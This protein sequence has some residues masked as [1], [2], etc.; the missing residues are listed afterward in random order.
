[1]GNVAA[2]GALVA[3]LGIGNEPGAF[4]QQGTFSPAGAWTRSARFP[5]SSRRCGFVAV[6]LAIPFSPGSCRDRSGDPAA[7]NAV[8]SS[9][10]GCGHR[11]A[12]WPHRR[13]ADSNDN[14]S[15]MDR[16]AWYAKGEGITRVSCCAAVWPPRPQRLVTHFRCEV[17]RQCFMPTT[18]K[19]QSRCTDEEAFKNIG[20][21][22]ESRLRLHRGR[23]CCIDPSRVFF[24]ATTLSRIGDVRAPYS[25]QHAMRTAIRAVIF[26]VSD[27]PSG[28]SLRH[29]YYNKQRAVKIRYACPATATIRLPLPLRYCAI[30]S[31]GSSSRQPVRCASCCRSSIV[32]RSVTKRVLAVS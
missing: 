13:T 2:D 27:A 12:T 15:P 18:R 14:A 16:G 25:P 6:F 21:R 19:W 29:R 28:L 7:Q 32:S 3:H 24:L 11:R 17:A 26:R 20:P 5:W 30:S 4:D 8:S 10:A 31:A 22:A 9:A 23:T 1:M